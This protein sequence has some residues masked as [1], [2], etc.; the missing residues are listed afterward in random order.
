MVRPKKLKQGDK[1]AIL[2]PSFS[3]P[4]KWPHVYELGLSR[5]R[6]GF[7][8]EPVEFPTTKKISATREERARDLIA[9]FKDKETKAVLAT[10][11][12]NDQVIYIKNLSP[13]PFK[14]NPKPFFGYSDN[15]HFANFLWLH[16][17]SSYYGGGI[18][19]QFAMQKK[20]DAFTVEFLNHALF[21]EGEYELR[22][23]ESINDQ[24]LDWNEPT[25]LNQERIHEPNDGWRWSGNIS[26]EGLSWGGCLESIDEMI[27]HNITIPSLEDFENAILMT[28]TAEEMPSAEYVFRV[29]RAL[30]ERGVLERV[31]GILVGRPKA[32]NL[33]K[34]NT[35][36]QKKAYR[37]KQ[38][39]T[40]ENTVRQYNKRIP[41]IQNL[42]FG[43]TDPQIPL[44]Y[45]GKIQI[46]TENKKIFAEF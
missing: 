22:A 9:A 3:A 31:R 43:H 15:S 32:W 35:P 19:T 44:P 18:M 41:I 10:F 8:L 40:I 34:K 27:R 28:E 33:E 21:D 23:S 5:L 13:E 14:E 29:Y 42:D 6:E 45:G 2:S 20:M 37:E 38:Y 24:E 17:I 12:G 36:E 1:V 26:S 11:G 7:G 46:D 30:G 39:E 4:G 25:T 16:G